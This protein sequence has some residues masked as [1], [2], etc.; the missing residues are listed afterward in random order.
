MIIRL[1]NNITSK[2]YSIFI[3]ATIGLIIALFFTFIVYPSISQQYNAVLDPD[4][5]GNLGYGLLKT[6][7]LAFHPD[8]EP[9]LV[10]GPVYPIFIAFCLAISNGLWPYSIQF[11]QCILFALIILTMFFTA[12][13][14]WNRNVAFIASVLCTLHP[15]LIWYTSRIWVELFAAFL[16]ILHY[17]ALSLFF[18]KPSYKTALIVGVM[19]GILALTK[20][21]FLFFTI[22]IPLFML[23][24]KIDNRKI[25]IRQSMILI[26]ASFIIILPWTARNYAISGKII[27]VHLLAGIN[28]QIGDGVTE[29]FI[30]SSS[31]DKRLSFAYLWDISL[32][33]RSEIYKKFPEKISLWEK[34]YKADKEMIAQSFS[35]YAKEP[36]FLIKKIILNSW[37]FWILGENLKKTMIISVIQLPILIFFLISFALIIVKKKFFTIKGLFFILPLIYYMLHL[38][39]VCNARY[40]SVLAPVMIMCCVTFLESRLSDSSNTK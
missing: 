15:F 10:R 23:C 7:T 9:T 27:P 32:Q 1:L 12:K 5:H 11:A 28:L 14:I 20:Q 16:L 24:I 33:R 34:E 13:T 8:T 36:F 30:N 18:K 22:I 38:P 40:S 17:W 6:G 39:I 26:F 31:M 3:L 37:M 2:K 4:L 19:G 25:P 21:T 35:R 29:G